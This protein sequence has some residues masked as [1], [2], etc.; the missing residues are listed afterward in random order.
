MVGPRRPLKLFGV[1]GILLFVLSL[2][3]VFIKTPRDF[4]NDDALRSR[5]PKCHHDSA[6]DPV[7]YNLDTRLGMQSS[8]VYDASHW[9]H[10]AEKFL[11]QYS[12]LRQGN[13]LNSN[14]SVVYFNFDKAGFLEDLNGFTRFLVHLGTADAVHSSSKLHFVYLQDAN[15]DRVSY[16][17]T[18]SFAWNDLK[19]HQTVDLLS[20]P[21]NKRA[22]KFEAVK[23]ITVKS[24]LAEDKVCVQYITTLGRSRPKK[25]HWFT[26]QQDVNNLRESIRKACPADAELL[27]LYR[28]RQ[29]FK[30]VIYQR[31]RSRLEHSV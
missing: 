17:D 1:V 9:F 6:T 31:N 22:D 14:A 11:A 2:L 4:S 26:T 21:N 20:T 23:A 24:A 10:V 18:M 12:A 27:K 8:L 7:L 25:G 16:R 28:K 3:N 5:Y 13:F 19:D 29:R 30:M 15:F